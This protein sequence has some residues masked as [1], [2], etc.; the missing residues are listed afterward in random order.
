[1]TS[2][3]RHLGAGARIIN[4]PVHGHVALP[5]H[6]WDAVDT[7]QF[8]RLRDLRQ[9]GASYYV[10]PGASHNRFEHSL[11]VSFLAAEMLQGLRARQPG[12]EVSDRDVQLVQLAGL[13]HDIGHGPFSHAFEDWVHG[14]PGSAGSAVASF[15]HESMSQRLVRNLVEEHAL[16]YDDRDLRFINS[17][18]EGDS[19]AFP[20]RPFLYDIVSNQRNSIDVDKFD[21]LARDGHNLGMKLSYDSSRLMAHSRIIDNQICF[22]S[23]EVFN[24][25]EMFHARY[26]MFKQVYAHRVTKAIEYMIA[27]AFSAANPAFRIT[28]ALDDVSRYARLTD[29]LLTQIEFSSLTDDPGVA[30]AQAIIRSIRRRRLYKFACESMIPHARW[31]H[32]A[33]RVRAADIVCCGSSNYGELREDDII[34]QNLR[35]NYAMGDRNPV[36]RVQFYNSS[37]FGSSFSIPPQ[38]V[39]ELIPKVYMEKYVRVYVRNPD[40]AAAAQAA[41]D[42]YAMRNGLQLSRSHQKLVTPSPSPMPSL[43][44]HQ[45]PLYSDSHYAPGKRQRFLPPNSP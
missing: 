28:Y 40:H 18:I 2:S 6:C 5:Q 23:K 43:Q 24:V 42:V 32:F 1:M 35:M 38:E 20:G 12:L 44:Q 19:A 3:A 30:R 39:S 25:Y 14:L 22:H 15:K 29:S 37:D 8:Q 31:V 13:C 16:D 34:V 26:S 36:D 33:D 41:F 10:F 27:D 9:L 7:P 11:G 45:N 4:D 21:Y 17:L